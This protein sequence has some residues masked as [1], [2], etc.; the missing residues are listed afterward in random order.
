MCA[1]SGQRRATSAHSR[2]AWPQKSNGRSDGPV[3]SHGGA[4]GPAGG[5]PG[6][7]A[8]R[9]ARTGRRGSPAA[10]QDRANGERGGARYEVINA[11]SPPIGGPHATRSAPPRQAPERPGGRIRKVLPPGRPMTTGRIGTN[12]PVR[13]TIDH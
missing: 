11:P 8:G 13:G 4:S 12:G 2:R 1:S 6:G 3:V 7:R 10:L 5:G 9:G